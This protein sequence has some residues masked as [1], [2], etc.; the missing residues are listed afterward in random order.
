MVA[1]GA[2][3]FL[4]KGALDLAYIVDLTTPGKVRVEVARREEADADG[5]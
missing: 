2:D 5:S 3:D 1:A 4:V